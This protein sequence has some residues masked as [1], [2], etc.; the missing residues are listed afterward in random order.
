MLR[1]VYIIVHP[2]HHIGQGI[3]DDGM[4][5]LPPNNILQC[6]TSLSL[7]NCPP[8]AQNNNNRFQSPL[9][10]CSLNHKYAIADNK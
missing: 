2:S 9:Q 5:V 4:E 7:G 10:C 1:M 8:R 6:Q 3:D